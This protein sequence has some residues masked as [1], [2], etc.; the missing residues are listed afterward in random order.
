[1]EKRDRTEIDTQRENELIDQ[2]T[3]LQVRL[4]IGL[5]AKK[6]RSLFYFRLPLPPSAPLFLLSCEQWE[7]MAVVQPK[8]GS[9]VPGAPTNWQLMPGMESRIPVIFLDL[10]R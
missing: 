3:M 10:T 4:A 8:A 2:W 9:G 1:M 6:C 7:R 5:L